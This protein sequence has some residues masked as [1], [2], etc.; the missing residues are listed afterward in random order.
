MTT[1]PPPTWNVTRL[2]SAAFYVLLAAALVLSRLVQ[3]D[4]SFWQ[5]EIYFV[6][7]FVR[8]G[9]GEILGG[10]DL[11]HELYGLL[12]WATAEI[13]GESELAFRLW[14]AIPFIVGVLVVAAWLHTRLSSTAGLL[15]V[16]LATV[17]PL[18]LDLSRQA[19]GYGLAF[20]AMSVLIIA[21]LEADRTAQALAVTVMCVA[22]VLGTWTLPQFGIAFLSTGVILLAD[23]RNRKT[24][25]V[26]LLSSAV[27]IVAWYAPHLNQIHTSSQVENGERISTAWL[28]TAPIDQILLPGLVWIEGT[29]LLAG[30]IWLPLVL[31]AVLVIGSSPYVHDRNVGLI[32]CSA[33]VVTI[34]AL[35]A[36]G[37][38][39]WPRYLSY[40]LV[41]FFVLLSSGASAI[42]E[43]SGTRPALLRTVLCLVA[44][45]LLAAN[46]VSVAPDVVRLPRQANR[47]AAQ[48]I[49]TRSP[50]S[51][52][53]L[54]YLTA[55]SN[56]AFYL[57]RPVRSLDGTDVASRVCN[58]AVPVAYVMEPFGVEPVDVPCLRRAGV[59]HVRFPQYAGGGE[60]NV[61]FVP[62]N[63]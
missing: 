9:P 53:V 28:L 35:W 34:A 8:E 21:A 6:G 41:P 7:H 5:D 31:L 33:P 29:A 24:T 32:L 38:Y 20:L 46:F 62:P 60:M 48:L 55:P 37:A 54:A 3:L 61:W 47:D 18:L 52:P 10:P 63:G 43:R 39:V 25:A 45:A 58:E 1:S 36:F 4:K 13:A 23:R 30:P 12:T 50:S 19:R 16:F 17:S 26:G 57:D 11:S 44:I 42:L 15:F 2:I 22:G 56:L 59:E 40:L 51:T 49:E 27:A 14:S